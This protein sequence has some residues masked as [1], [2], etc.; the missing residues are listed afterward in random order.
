MKNKSIPCLVFCALLSACSSGS[1][2]TGINNSDTSSA[3]TS[4]AD[5]NS[6]SEDGS[7][8]T[9]AMPVQDIVL[10]GAFLDTWV[11]GLRYKTPTLQ[12][13][14]DADGQFQYRPGEIVT[15]AIKNV[16]V[17]SAP[18]SA[19][20]TP[21]SLARFKILETP[22]ESDYVDTLV[23]LQ[24][25][26]VNQS[27][28]NRIQLDEAKPP[29]TD[30]F[31]DQEDS[32]I[33]IVDVLS[34]L[35]EIGRVVEN[36]VALAHFGAST[37]SQLN[38]YTTDLASIFADN[39]RETEEVELQQTIASHY[40]EEIYLSSLVYEDELPPNPDDYM[41]MRGWNLVLEEFDNETGFKA[42]L[43]QKLGTHRYV[44]AFGGTG[45]GR[46]SLSEKEKLR[47]LSNDLETDIA[48][49]NPGGNN[50][51]KDD[52]KS[53]VSQ[54][55]EKIGELSDSVDIGDIEITFTGHSLGGGIAR[56]AT[57]LY[58]YPSVTV[59]S[60]PLPITFA[61]I[62]EF[63]QARVSSFINNDGKTDY[64]FTHAGK[65]TNIQNKNDPLTLLMD[66]IVKADRSPES[67]SAATKQVMGQLKSRFDVPAFLSLNYLNTGATFTVQ[68]E[69][70]HSIQSVVDWVDRLLQDRDFDQIQDSVEIA[71]GTNPDEFDSDGDGIS[72][73]NEIGAV[74]APLDSDSDGVIDALDPVSS[75]GVTA[76]GDP[77]PDSL[78]T[79]VIQLEVVDSAELLAFEWNLVSDASRY[80]VLVADGP[81]GTVL[82]VVHQIETNAITISDVDIGTTYYVSV[83]AVF[84]ASADEESI[85]N[86][87]SSAES[88]VIIVNVS[89]RPN[90]GTA[91]LTQVASS[92]EF[93]G[94][95][96][97]GAIPR[98]VDVS[99]DGR[100]VLF[101]V[102]EINENNETI[103]K[104]FHQ[105]MS[106]GDR[107][108]VRTNTRD[109]NNARISGDGSKVVFEASDQNVYLWDEADENITL[110]S[111]TYNNTAGV[112]NGVS[113]KPVIDFDGSDIYYSST[114]TDLVPETSTFDSNLYHYNVEQTTTTLISNSRDGD[115]RQGDVS[116][117]HITP[118][119]R[120]V[121]LRFSVPQIVIMT[122]RYDSLTD[123][124]IEFS[125]GGEVAGSSFNG[126]S[127][128][129][130]IAAFQVTGRARLHNISGSSFVDIWNGSRFSS[131]IDMSDD[132]RF[133][134]VR[135]NQEIAD[136]VPENG[137][138]SGYYLY[139]SRLEVTY[140]S[141]LGVQ[142]LAISGDGE[143]VIYQ[144]ANPGSSSL[145]VTDRREIFGN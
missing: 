57:L 80:E 74:D 6:T 122:M 123:E 108:L 105:N 26:N 51:I 88:E 84:D 17:G 132:G 68:S 140:E 133:S 62:E 118:D 85:A 131:P 22:A 106:T 100:Y 31:F 135:A 102:A 45:A 40:G 34:K 7:G 28:S 110:I 77:E 39:S 129:A 125:F 9:I 75:S 121:F 60:A 3:D 59:N 53:F 25:L 124:A 115:S 134:L 65:I 49:I 43:Y 83:R 50:V 24:S 107:K 109:S 5:S 82:P 11:S 141:I 92:V 96:N 71:L 98:Y 145:F 128:L 36:P 20:V 112:A 76:A 1:N 41:P 38:S 142:V 94:R 72:D 120:Y 30:E 127:V 73:F 103:R 81:R 46:A 19:I 89:Q 95:T 4:S 93:N 18:G 42:G 16:E 52:T 113:R 70:G 104:L 136:I 55:I 90:A 44:I 21:A 64:E 78:S 117:D 130:Q 58:G 144:E 61:D 54:S 114:A 23:L 91:A 12:G 138:Y 87:E 79:Q 33:T 56:Y 69:G 63:G 111:H 27:N 37:A 14:T 13:V 99:Q 15:F 119:G 29:L 97:F 47:D 32:N 66:L 101:H 35:R 126:N 137:F 139:D 8:L 2:N 67:V 116:P 10:T 143:T 48:L 86:A